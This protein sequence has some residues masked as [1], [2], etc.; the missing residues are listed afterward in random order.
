MPD[1]ESGE[2]KSFESSSGTAPLDA[3]L[4]RALEETLL[5]HDMA[6]RQFIVRALAAGIAGVLI[7]V[8]V[9]LALGTL[10]SADARSLL[11]LV[12]S[13]MFTLAGTAVA[14]H[15]RSRP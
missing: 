15:Y 14:F 9:L 6:S 7:G 1:D 11:P 4:R 10:T 8:G 5:A 3:S 12:L 2:W 13:P